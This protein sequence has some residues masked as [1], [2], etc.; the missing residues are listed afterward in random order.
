MIAGIRLA[1]EIPSDLPANWIFQFWLDRERHEAR[2]IARR[3][4]LLFSLSWLVPACF[5]VTLFFWGGLAALLHTA[6]LILCTVVLVEVLLLKFRK[7]PFTCPY[8]SFKSHSG[9]IAV[10]YLFGYV[11]FTYYL[12]QMEDWSLSDPWRVVWFAPLLWMAL[13]GIHLYRKQMLDMD[14]EL[15]FE[16][17]SAPGFD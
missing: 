9:L 2:P 5:L 1:F 8:P 17:V 12:P 15:V 4:L 10:A 16:D 14:K 11:F 3:V 13:A 7:I 6:I